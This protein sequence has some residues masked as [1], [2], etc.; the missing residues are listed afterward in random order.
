MSLTPIYNLIERLAMD[1]YDIID[2][3]LFS[4][5]CLGFFVYETNL[6]LLMLYLMT[7]INKRMY[8]VGMN[9]CEL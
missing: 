2:H 9:I 6:L 8:N 5:S 7:Q 1:K 4:C 3:L